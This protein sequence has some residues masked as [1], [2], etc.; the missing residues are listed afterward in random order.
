[1]RKRV[2]SRGVCSGLPGGC[3]EETWVRLSLTGIKN[4]MLVLLSP[5]VSSGFCYLQDGTWKLWRARRCVSFSADLL[6]VFECLTLV[7]AMS[8]KAWWINSAEQCLA[9]RLVRC[10]INCSSLECFTKKEILVHSFGDKDLAS[11]I[12][13]LSPGWISLLDPL[14][15]FLMPLWKIPHH[16][17]GPQRWCKLA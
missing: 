15:L 12:S 5:D 1:M 13:L 4:F 14:P 11:G 17:L 16:S 10:R 7:T 2:D 9:L 8:V 6:F 3:C